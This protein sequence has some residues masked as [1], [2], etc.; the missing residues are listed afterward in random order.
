MQHKILILISVIIAFVFINIFCPLVTLATNNNNNIYKIEEVE[1]GGIKQYIQI[2]GENK[3]NPVILFLHGGPGYAQISYAHKYQSKIEKNFVVINWDQRGAGKSYNK[4]INRESMT[5]E[6]FL[7]DTNEVIDYLIK[8][9]NKNKIYLAGHSWGS[10]LGIFT[11]KRYPDKLY[12]YIGIGQA[13]DYL[14]GE[15]ISYEYT[16]SRAKKD[17]NKK[18]LEDL[19]EIGYPPYKNIHDLMLERKW[20]AYYDGVEIKTNTLRDI[21]CGI[22]FYPGYSWLD[23]IRFY[24]GNKFSMDTISSSFNYIQNGETEVNLFKQVPHLKV[25]VYFCM[26]RNDYNTPFELVEEYYK[27]LKAPKKELYWFEESAHFPHFEE[28]DKFTEILLNI[29]KETNEKTNAKNIQK[30]KYL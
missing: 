9:F 16:L 11:A 29:L 27:K 23:G 22:L 15:K 19:N 6:Q 18:A 21:I 4:N 14:K 1:I 24:K 5:L 7:A 20:L 13:I 26:G 10:L 12:A 25:P 3:N 17:N 8:K 28:P 30:H 2:R